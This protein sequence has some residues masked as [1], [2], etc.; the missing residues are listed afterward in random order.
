MI[1]AVEN[2]GLLDAKTEGNQIYVPR[3]EQERYLVALK[4]T[5]A[6][7]LAIDDSVDQAVANS[8]LFASP[9]QIE[10]DQKHAE[11]KKLARIV[12][13]MQG[14]ETSS[15]QYDEVRKPGFPP[16]VE[17]RASV[18]VR[19]VGGRTLD[20]E[21]IE[22]IRDTVAGYVA[23]LDRTQVTVTDLVACRAYPGSY[24]ASD[25]LAAGRAYATLKRLL[26][27]EYRANIEG[28]LQM[29]PGA[30]VGVDVNLSASTDTPGGAMA[31]GAPMV[32][33]LVRASISL[34]QTLIEDHCRRRNR[35]PEGAMSSS[36]QLRESEQ[37]IRSNVERTV[38]AM[39]PPPAP[40]MQTT[41][42]VTVTSHWDEPSASPR[43]EPIGALGLWLGTH[44]L[45]AI[46]GAVAI[47]VVVIGT[48]YYARS[49]TSR[50]RSAGK[51]L[52][53][54]TGVPVSAGSAAPESDEEGS[55]SLDVREAI[56]KLVRENPESAA[57]LIRNWLD[58]AA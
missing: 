40:H 9:G 27:D 58:K 36:D 20:Y 5:D 52:T 38:L 49:L 43:S 16:T 14:I 33:A 37:E 42:Q 50:S 34:P 41:E 23:G 53:E 25:P 54:G 19:A 6:L 2:A 39:L 46:L 15:V 12:A 57:D 45:L 4:A 28:H 29:Y 21:Q 56:A 30:V 11:Q 13:S 22:A 7:P 10:R 3:G 24:D 18:A 26:E 35:L 51:D 44:Y 55:A 8:G 17:V 31:G 1:S 48:A 32:P 47:V